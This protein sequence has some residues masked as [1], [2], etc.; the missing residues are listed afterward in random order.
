MTEQAA[1]LTVKVKLHAAQ[2]VVLPTQAAPARFSKLKL[3]VGALVL[4]LLSGF[5]YLLWLNFLA[6]VPAAVAADHHPL[7][8]TQPIQQAMPTSAAAVTLLTS[9]EETVVDPKDAE[10]IATSVK[11]TTAVD[12][13][14]L[15]PASVAS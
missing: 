15:L 7:Q 5:G 3:T 14:V 10:P 4:L 8:Q 12:I 9:P 6:K 13:D 11:A 1:K 2:P